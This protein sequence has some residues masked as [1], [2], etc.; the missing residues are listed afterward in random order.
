MSPV[1][2]S[3]MGGTIVNFKGNGFKTTGTSVVIGSS[4][5]NIMEET[6][7]NFA[8]TNIGHIQS[9]EL[10]HHPVEYI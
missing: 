5:C 2:G 9:F 7:T 8:V 1:H 6:L 4:N 3:E 10:C